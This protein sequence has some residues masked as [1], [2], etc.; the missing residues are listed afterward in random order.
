MAVLKCRTPINEHKDPISVELWHYSNGMTFKIEKYKC[1][2]L[3]IV[4]LLKNYPEHYNF[5]DLPV[6]YFTNPITAHK[7]IKKYTWQP[8]HYGH[9]LY[10]ENE[11]G[12]LLVGDDSL[13]AL[14]QWGQDVE[15]DDKTLF[16][17]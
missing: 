3:R 15:Q 16:R 1:L 14:A 11:Q 5:A 6:T 13:L 17:S 4:D 8:P 7:Q 10:R 9:W 2:C 12:E